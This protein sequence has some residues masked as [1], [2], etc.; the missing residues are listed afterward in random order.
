[1]EVFS[2]LPANNAFVAVHYAH[3]LKDV[4]SWTLRPGAGLAVSVSWSVLLL[5][6][7]LLVHVWL[8]RRVIV[9]E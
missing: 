4:A 1:M 8:Y 6:V 2:G 7:V 3:A 9:G 5:F